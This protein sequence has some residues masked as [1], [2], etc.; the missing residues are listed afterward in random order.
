MEGGQL[1][2]LPFAVQ[3]IRRL[4][5]QRGVPEGEGRSLAVLA[6]G[7]GTR[8]YPLTAAE[9][10]NKSMIR[11]PAQIGRY[12]LRIVEL[13][14][15]QYH[16]ILDE[17]EPGRIHVA[18]GDH[19]L[20][21]TRTPRCVGGQPVQVFANSASFVAETRA[22]DLIDAS[23]EPR[24]SDPI[25][26]RVRLSRIDVPSQLPVLHSLTQMGLV[27]A[28]AEEEGLLY[29]VEKAGV[30]DILEAFAEAGARARVNWWD[31]SLSPDAARLLTKSYAD[32]IGAGID[33]SMDVLEPVTMDREAWCHR[34]PSR[35]AALWDRA[36]AL[37]QNSTLPRNTPLGPIGVA[38][39]GEGSDF[40]DLGTLKTMYETFATA[41]V[42]GRGERYRRLLGARLEN[43]AL[44]VGEGP[45]PG[46]DVEPGSIV[47]GGTGIRSGRVGAGSII[48]DPRVAELRTWG[49]SIAYGVWAPRGRVSVHDGQVAAGVLHLGRRLT[50]W[51]SLWAP[52][53][54][55][56]SLE[57]ESSPVRKRHELLGSLLRGEEPGAGFR[58]TVPPERLE[59]SLCFPPPR[60]QEE[61]QRRTRRPRGRRRTGRQRAHVPW[62]LSPA[63]LVRPRGRGREVLGHGLARSFKEWCWPCTPGP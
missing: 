57:L 25:D 24:W 9:G 28:S 44:F 55:R 60:G 35:N 59:Q 3:R 54:R 23:L 14:I 62:P 13:V 33:F 39:P 26:L 36:N 58:G 48:V 32:L 8:A 63:P 22:A 11:T 47:I 42:T 43:G 50:V 29:L 10:G 27:K 37:F 41:L 20:S 18:A 4:L 52:Q 40:A 17:V 2:R 6:A 5:T 38:D 16:Q 1:R 49:R 15:A 51:A 19:L 12:P 45:P 46:V 7:H 53:E 61:C 30:A 34:R 31:W 21:W 56:R